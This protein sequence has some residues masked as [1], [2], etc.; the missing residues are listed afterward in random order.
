MKAGVRQKKKPYVRKIPT[1]ISRVM[2]VRLDPSI[3]IFFP[4]FILE[5]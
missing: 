3:F 1:S 4:T 5:M 2:Y